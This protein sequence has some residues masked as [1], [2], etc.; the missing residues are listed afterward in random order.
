[1][2]RGGHSGRGSTSSGVPSTFVGRGVCLPADYTDCSSDRVRLPDYASCPGN[3]VRLP[4]DYA[5][6]PG[7]RVRLPDYTGCPGDRVCLSPSSVICPIPFSSRC[8]EPSS[9][10]EGGGLA[11]WTPAILDFW[12]RYMFTTPEDLPRARVVWESTG[13]IN[14]RKSMWEVRDKAAK[15]TGS[16]DPTAWM[17]YGPVWMRRDYWES[18][19]QQ[20]AT[21]PWQKRSQAAKRNRA[22]HLEKNVHTSGLRHELECAP[23]F[24]ELFDRTHKRKGT[25]DYV[26]ESART[27]AETYDKMMVDRYVEG[28]PH[29]DLDLEAW[30]DAAEGPKKGRV[31]GFRDSLDTTPVL[32]SYASSISP[33]AYASSSAATPGSGGEDIRTLIREELSQQLPL[34][35]GAMVE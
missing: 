31:Y 17:D 11:S 13:Q 3:K 34:H 2:V 8:R 19:C 23:T 28:T 7:D 10:G 30:V 15:T 33:P 14:F 27:I 35:L 9:S 22:A 21:G 20:W 29:P 16:Q 24:R 25:D 4:A 1:M 26:S 12:R 18:L 32:S 5:G 6:C